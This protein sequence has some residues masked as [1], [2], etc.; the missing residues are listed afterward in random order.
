[1]IINSRLKKYQLQFGSF[2]SFSELKKNNNQIVIISDVFFKKD[3]R[4]KKFKRK[5]FV[6][7]NEQSKSFENLNHLIKKL[8]EIKVDKKTIL[9]ALGG[10]VIQDIVS[11]IASI[12]FRGIDWYFIPTTL[13]AMGDSCIGGKTSINFYGIKNQLGNFYPPNQILIDINFID[14]LPIDQIN[15]GV[16][17]ISHYYFVGN[18]ENIKYLLK[19]FINKNYK[20]LILNSLKIKKAIIEQDEFDNNVRLLLNFGHTFGHAL[21]SYYN[22]KIPHGCAVVI[23]MKLS[24]FI[25][26]KLK[27]ISEK[28]LTDFNNILDQIYYEKKLLLK[29][30]NINKYFILLSKDKKM[31]KGKL[32]PIL[33]KGIG[34]MFITSISLDV[35]F[36]KLVKQF[37]I[38]Y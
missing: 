34:K 13:L 2:D 19:F 37:F 26:N 32:R 31:M 6:N 4:L 9:L 35:R 18:K 23:G 5:I 21:E 1:M 3:I 30:I 16:G 20:S 22:Y 7:A 36:K 27:Y 15:S 11:F 10:G 38:N 17:E 33:T 14:T 12:L 29:N 25:S 24:V 28:T 8:L